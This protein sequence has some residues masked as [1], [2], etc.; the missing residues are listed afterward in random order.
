MEKMVD[1]AT[2]DFWAKRSN[3]LTPRSITLNEKYPTLK[4]KQKHCFPLVIRVFYSFIFIFHFYLISN[5]S[6]L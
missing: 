6:S 1:L 2:A 4:I 5:V 3:P